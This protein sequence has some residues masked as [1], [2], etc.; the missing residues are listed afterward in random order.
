MSRYL[1]G[2]SGG[3]T[4][5][6]IEEEIQYVY[7]MLLTPPRKVTDTNYVGINSVLFDTST[8][9]PIDIS[10]YK[11]SGTNHVTNSGDGK[12]LVIYNNRKN[13]AVTYAKNLSEIQ[14]KYND[15]VVAIGG[16]DFDNIP[17]AKIP[18]ART[19][20]GFKD[21]KIY[22]GVTRTSLDAVTASTLKSDIQTLG[23]NTNNVVVLDGGGSTKMQAKGANGAKLILGS[24]ENREVVGMVVTGE[25]V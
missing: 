9:K 12:T 21:G 2:Y 24:I 13:V 8:N 22:M 7:P 5:G 14:A 19:W 6:V 3:R 1:E 17:D 15:V 18:R 11:Y 10:Y 4:Y 16:R 20:I 25:H 23:F